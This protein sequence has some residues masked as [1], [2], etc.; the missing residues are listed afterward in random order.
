MREYITWDGRL[1]YISH[2]TDKISYLEGIKL[3]LEGG[4]QWIQLRM[5]GATDD[6]VRPIAHRV[7]ELCEAAHAKFILD[8]RV[9]LVKEVGADGV[10][11]GKNDMPI[12]EARKILGDNFIIGGTANTFEDVK[13]HAEAG[14]DY[15]GCGPFRFTTTKEKLSPVLGLEGYRHI[16]EQMKAANIHLPVVAI[17]GITIDDIPDIMQTGVT[18]I[19]LSGSI[20]RAINPARETQEILKALEAETK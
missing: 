12:A 5:K 13:A 4:C 9:K 14:A 10:H 8:D 18:G 15:I 2:Y 16:V 11:L 7:K 20:L 19:A 17:G 6:E 3:A 1:Q